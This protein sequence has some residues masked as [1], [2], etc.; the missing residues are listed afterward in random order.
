MQ[1]RIINPTDGI[2]PATEDY[3]HALEISGAKR[4]L[5]VSGTMGLAQDGTPPEGL[6][7]QL[8]LV[9]SNIRTILSAA[10]M[11]MD[12][13]IR[14]TSY[15]TDTAHAEKNQNARLKALGKRR[16]PTTAIVVQTLESR[17][18]VEIEIIAMA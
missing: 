11:S 2:Y 4:Q 10:D 3:V 13:I 15:L 17:W 9:W 12:N 14:V 6:D 16:I 18:L 8:D 5:F 7:E 1:Q